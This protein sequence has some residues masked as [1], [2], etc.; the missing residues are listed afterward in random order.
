MAAIAGT[1][2]DRM[3][4]RAALLVLLAVLAAAVA[5][6]TSLWVPTLVTVI[7]S[8]WSNGVMWNF[9]EEKPRYQWSDT[10]LSFAAFLSLVTFLASIVILVGAIAIG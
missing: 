9:R 5:Y 2:H 6:P 4:V 1:P 10:A 7:L 3:T 8:F